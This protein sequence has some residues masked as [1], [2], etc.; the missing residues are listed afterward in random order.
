MQP[1]YDDVL[2][3]AT[4]L[5][6]V[7]VRTPVLH[8]DELD[9]RVG[10]SVFVKAEALQRGGAF[11]LRGAFNKLLSLTPDERAGGVV[12]VSSG[13]H[14]I[15][16]ALGAKLLGI[17]ATILVP[18]DAPAAKID[19]AR[20][21]GAEIVTFDR[22]TEDRDAVTA[23]FVAERGLPFIPP[24]DDPAI[25]AGQGTVALEL[26]DETGDLDALVV[27]VSGGGLIAGCGIV[28]TARC[29]TVRMIGVEPAAM[30]DTRRSLVAGERVSV[31]VTATLADGL[32]V[33]APGRLTWEINRRLLDS[34]VTVSDDELVGAMRVTFELL[35]VVGEPSGVAGVAALL[36]GIPGLSGRRVGVVLSGGNVGLD[37][38]LSL[39]ASPTGGD[40]VPDG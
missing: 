13:N 35:H 31:P 23:A 3:A 16:V 33:A 40:G 8:S 29:P 28:A 21:H 25:I 2:R 24:F 7:T 17:P 5:S 26:L 37:R 14:A 38:F 4:A 34:V 9:D 15:A 12:A 20:A 18:E 39:V 1:S 11:K 6:G 32:T 36:Q 30:D 19:R 22:F 10:A 27:P